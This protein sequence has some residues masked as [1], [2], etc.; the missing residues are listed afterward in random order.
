[1]PPKRPQASAARTPSWQLPSAAAGAR[2]RLMRL[3][4][5][6]PLTAALLAGVLVSAGDLPAQSRKPAAKPA[7]TVTPAAEKAKVPEEKPAA[8]DG[9]APAA[10]EP[11]LTPP[12]APAP[13]RLTE[14]A[15]GL[16]PA[17]RRQFDEFFE[18]VKRGET[19]FAYNRLLEDS[20]L[21]QQREEMLKLV[22]STDKALRQYGQV[23]ET[24]LISVT[25]A[26]TRL[27][28]VVFLSACEAR[29]LQWTFMCY[30]AQK[31]WRILDINVTGELADMLPPLPPAAA[32]PVR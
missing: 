18:R 23:E 1:M 14:V 7:R 30:L 25:S 17:L 6:L 20:R 12:P 11:G 31:K 21:L 19:Q 13:L 10:E 15:A 2:L 27:H 32:V 4:R 5:P 24:E 22:E 26:G 3:L 8:P 9:A 28:R 16:D 29:P